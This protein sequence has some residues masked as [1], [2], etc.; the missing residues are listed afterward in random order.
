MK[1]LIT[2]LLVT[3]M[4]GACAPP[5]DGPPVTRAP[6]LPTPAVTPA[7][8]HVPGTVE[9]PAGHYLFVES[10]TDTAGEQCE[11]SLMIDFPTYGYDCPACGGRARIPAGAQ[12]E[13]LSAEGVRGEPDPARLRGFAGSGESVSGI[14]G[15]ISSELHPIHDLPYTIPSAET[16]TV[17][18]SVAAGGS[19]VVE[20][21]E[22]M[23]LLGPGESWV[24]TGYA[25]EE[26][27]DG[28]Y[29][30]GTPAP[31]ACYAVV[32]ERVTN[33]GWLPA[34]QIDVGVVIQTEE[35]GGT[36]G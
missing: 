9:Q 28:W 24:R 36:D 25:D 21:G 1:W 12:I 31:Q 19:I 30:P 16:E 23:V 34:G 7:P 26:V 29:P 18:R 6:L 10:W 5:E 4:V 2:L 32:T 35:G 13:G 33:F 27:L 17:V 22:E 14:G 3:G 11:V 20:V 15:G 8:E